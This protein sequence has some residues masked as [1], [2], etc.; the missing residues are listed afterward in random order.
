MV[1]MCNDISETVG[2]SHRCN[3]RKCQTK[4][5]KNP[6]KIFSTK[7]EKDHEFITLLYQK[8]S[9]NILPSGRSSRSIIVDVKKKIGEKFE[10]CCELQRLIGTHVEKKEIKYNYWK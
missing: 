3:Q 10:C 4:G 5:S 2:L 8:M 9:G 1:M 7:N 6:N